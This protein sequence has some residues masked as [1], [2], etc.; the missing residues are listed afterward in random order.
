MI[1]KKNMV[2]Q[3]Y[4]T[5]KQVAELMHC[6]IKTVDRYRRSGILPYIKMGNTSNSKV[7]FDEGDVAEFM[8][9]RKYNSGL[10]THG[11]GWDYNSGFKPGGTLVTGSKEDRGVSDDTNETPYT[12]MDDFSDVPPEW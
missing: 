9:R 12:D 11:E 1:Y 10:R 5:K 3:K 8:A 6:S 7:L 2:K 4:L